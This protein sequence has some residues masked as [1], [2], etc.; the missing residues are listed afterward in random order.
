MTSPVIIYIYTYI[1]GST[2][3]II[4]LRLV[5]GYYINL[6]SYYVEETVCIY[7][8]YFV[9]YYCRK[10]FEL[11]VFKHCILELL[12][13]NVYV[14]I[15]VFSCYFNILDIFKIRKIFIVKLIY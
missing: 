9:K 15:E 3:L 12:F 1:Y 7:V 13:N 11:K 2:L 4:L 8:Y 10:N 5:Y 14:Y 6:F